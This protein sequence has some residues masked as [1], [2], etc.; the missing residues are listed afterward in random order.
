MRAFRSSAIRILLAWL[1]VAVFFSLENVLSGAARH[2][3]FS[4]QWDIFHEFIYWLMWAAATPLILAAGRRWPPFAGSAR[5]VWPHL[6]VMALIAPAQITSTYTAH[7]LIL[8]AAGVA[9]TSSL[10]AWLSGLFGGIVWGT[11]SG[12]LCYWLIIGAQSALRYQR[13]T[14]E[15]EQSLTATKL[16]ALRL[17]LQPHFLFNTLNAITAYIGADPDTAHRMVLRLGELLRSTLD[18][19]TA[20]QVPLKRELQLLA[21]YLEIQQTRFGDRLRIDIDVE[22]GA[23]NVRVPPLL[24]QPIVENAIEH[25]ITRRAGDGRIVLSARINNGRL[26]LEITDDGPGPGG[27]DD[28]V[29]LANTRERLAR[30]YGA[31]QSFELASAGASGTRVTIDLPS[32]TEG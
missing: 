14:A 26:R 19:G 11:F 1:A 25:G 9:P 17:Q 6:A 32:R 4:W 7:Y 3:A 13:L 31:E 27:G 15:L 30:L 5:M 18:V 12:F 22:A 2:H 21:P 23:R 8:S 24:L 28:G 16:E 10:G 29:G 20:Q